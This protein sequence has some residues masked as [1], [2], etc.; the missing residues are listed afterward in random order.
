[1]PSVQY[2]REFI[3]ERLTAAAEEIFTEFEK[4]IVQYEEEIGRQRRLLDITWKPEIKLHRTELPQPYV[5]EREGGLT[6]QQLCN[7]ERSSSRDQEEPEPP[8][9]KQE[10]E[11]LCSIQ[12]GEQ[13]ALK[14]ESDTFMVTA[15]YNKR[16]H[17]ESEPDCEQLLS[18]SSAVAESRDQGEGKNV[19]SGST[20]KP[21][22]KPKE[23]LYINR[24]HSS[25]AEESPTSETR[26]HTDTD[27]PQ[28]HVYKEQQEVLSEQEFC[29]K[30][31]SSNLEQEEPEPPQIKD[32]G[33][34]PCTSQEGEQLVLENDTFMVTATYE[35]RDHIPNR[36]QL[37]SHSTAVAESQNHEG[38]KTV[39][40]G[41]SKNSELKKRLHRNRSHINNLEDSP[42]SK[43]CSNSDTGKKSLKCDFCGKTFKKKSQMKEHHR[44]HTGEKPYSCKACGKNFTRSRN[45]TV[46]MRTHTGE[47]PYHCKM[48]GKTFTRSS[49]LPLHIRTHTG[50]KLYPCKICGK[51]LSRRGYLLAHIRTH[52]GEKPYECKTC[53]KMFISSKNLLRHSKTHTGQKS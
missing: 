12:E 28:Q 29:N 3:N 2:L 4:T 49:S 6:E 18:H 51:V 19:D 42:P 39:D 14:E 46:H 40:S 52:T 1:M 23:R 41:S 36:D 21:E 48:C 8:Q 30:E 37:Y 13:R 50:E 33:E 26:C 20:R 5:S 7:Q 15:T 17:S 24:S 31:W 25:N 35:E 47:K 16:D 9:I 34:E 32:E 10:Q 44:S 11:E 22:S 43:S 53:G 45:L 38:S 27:L